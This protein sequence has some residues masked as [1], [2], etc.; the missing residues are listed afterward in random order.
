MKILNFKNLSF[1]FI[2]FCSQYIF[3]QV[4]IKK[5]WHQ[6]VY[7]D[8][9]AITQS[10]T[11]NLTNFEPWTNIEE[12]QVSGDKNYLFIRY[13]PNNSGKA[14]R[15]LLYSLKSLTKI[16]EII[17]GFGGLFEWNENNQIIHIWGCGS[18]CG[19]CRIY[20]INLQEIFYTFSTGG[21]KLSPDKNKLVQFHMWGNK[22]FVLNLESID[23]QRSVESYYY[24]LPKGNLWDNFKF[25]DNQTIQISGKIIDLRKIEWKRIKEVNYEV[26]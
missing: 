7:N 13:K 26:R 18:N 17:P 21:F 5:L 6:Q 16:K 23:K 9:F 25:I 22:L 14:Y 12:Y 24:K 4:T 8:I 15:L 1:I 20:D 3:S 10:D 11:I 2:I 19:N